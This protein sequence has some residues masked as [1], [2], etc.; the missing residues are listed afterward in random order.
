MTHICGITLHSSKQTGALSWMVSNLSMNLVPS[1]AT[2]SSSASLRLHDEK[3]GAEN[4]GTVGAGGGCGTPQGDGA[5]V[6]RKSVLV[7]EILG[8][9]RRHSTRVPKHVLT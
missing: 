1:E 4:E 7:S 5:R 8:Y 9:M 6:D 2:K 3:M